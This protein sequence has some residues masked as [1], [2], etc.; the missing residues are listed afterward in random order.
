M[1]LI[2]ACAWYQTTQHVSVDG[3]YLSSKVLRGCAM[4]KPNDLNKLPSQLEQITRSISRVSEG[5]ISSGSR[6]SPSEIEFFLSQHNFGPD[7]GIEQ[8]EIST[9]GAFEFYMFAV[10]D[11]SSDGLSLLAMWPEQSVSPV[12]GGPCQNSE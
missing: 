10:S 9:D 8:I 5:G 6:P 3:V 7:A 2:D 12:A 1:K 11:R 4:D